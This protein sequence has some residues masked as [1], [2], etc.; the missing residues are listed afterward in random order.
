[1][2]HPAPGMAGGGEMEEVVPEIGLC[3]FQFQLAET[4]EI[5]AFPASV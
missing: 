2:Q 4:L 1:M 5:K 3:R